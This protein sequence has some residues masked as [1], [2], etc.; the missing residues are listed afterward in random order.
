M[1]LH[2][3]SAVRLHLMGVG[4]CNVGKA[5]GKQCVITGGHEFNPYLIIL[6]IMQLKNQL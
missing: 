6:V 4:T 1:F 3:I 5:W 2:Q